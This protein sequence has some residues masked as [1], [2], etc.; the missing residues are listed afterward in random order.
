M[1]LSFA[2]IYD[3]VLRDSRRHAASLAYFMDRMSLYDVSSTATTI[4]LYLIHEAKGPNTTLVTESIFDKTPITY[5]VTRTPKGDEMLEHYIGNDLAYSQPF[6][7]KKLAGS[8]MSH[9]ADYK[10]YETEKGVIYVASLVVNEDEFT[11]K[12][13]QVTEDSK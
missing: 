5:L 6:T 13:C 2:Q 11:I 1:C 4:A 9:N 3:R 10:R 12:F 7:A 8:I